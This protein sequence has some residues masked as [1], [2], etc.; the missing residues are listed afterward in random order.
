[1][2]PVKIYID[3]YKY[4]GQPR[5]DVDVYSLWDELLQSETYV[6][7]YLIIE[8][9]K[10]LFCNYLTCEAHHFINYTM[11]CEVSAMKWMHDRFTHQPIY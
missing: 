11:Y 4:D 6:D 3:Q 5:V 10:L 7:T 2:I 8:P 9:Q 1:M